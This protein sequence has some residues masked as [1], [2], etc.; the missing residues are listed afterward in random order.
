MLLPNMVLIKAMVEI[1][2]SYHT[3]VFREILHLRNSKCVPASPDHEQS[4]ICIM[5]K[6]FPPLHSGETG[7]KRVSDV[8]E[9]RDDSVNATLRILGPDSAVTY[10]NTYA[11]YKRYTD[12]RSIP[13]MFGEPEVTGEINKLPEAIHNPYTRSTSSPG[14]ARILVYPDCFD[15]TICGSDRGRVKRKRM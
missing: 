2:P 10:H 1:A 4:I 14:P 8:A 13:P 6:T 9:L 12:I 11:C 3:L 5:G 7:R 15:C